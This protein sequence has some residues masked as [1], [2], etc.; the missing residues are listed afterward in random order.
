V[1]RTVLS[2]HGPPARTARDFSAPAVSPCHGEHL[3]LDVTT[4]SLA[5]PDDRTSHVAQPAPARVAAKPYLKIRPES[6][7]AA[8]NLRDLWHFRDLLFALALRDV[9]LRYKQTA[10]G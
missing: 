2:W 9:R 4:E 3:S 8:L 1:R 10:L 5:V 6:G 7:W